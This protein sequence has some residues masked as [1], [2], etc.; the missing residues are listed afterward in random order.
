MTGVVKHAN[1]DL[2]VEPPTT[3]VTINHYQEI[4]CGE[5]NGTTFNDLEEVKQEEGDQ[6]GESR[7]WHIAANISLLIYYTAIYIGYSWRIN[8]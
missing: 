1:L 8:K 5:F 2:L 3:T 4:V 6:T 7:I